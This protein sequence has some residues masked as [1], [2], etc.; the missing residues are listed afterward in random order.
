MIWPTDHFWRMRD[1]IF[2]ILKTSLAA[3][4]KRSQWPRR[5]WWTMFS[6][7]SV[8]LIMLWIVRFQPVS[9]ITARL[10]PHLSVWASKISI[11][12]AKSVLTVRLA[13]KRLMISPRPGTL[14]HGTTWTVQPTCYILTANIPISAWNTPRTWTV[15]PRKRMPAR[16]L[17]WSIPLV[18]LRPGKITTAVFMVQ[19]TARPMPIHAQN[20]VWIPLKI[21]P[22]GSDTVILLLFGMISTV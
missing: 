15:S 1:L 22:S 11:P 4:G 20:S 14:I 9:H 21:T 3:H 7:I 17:M 2:R 18:R 13:W 10:T 8:I 6:L 12:N 19:S 16:C 5:W